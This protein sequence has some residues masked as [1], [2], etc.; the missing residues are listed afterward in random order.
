MAIAGWWTGY[1]GIGAVVLLL[2]DQLHSR[3]AYLV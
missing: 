2:A 1:A 3:L